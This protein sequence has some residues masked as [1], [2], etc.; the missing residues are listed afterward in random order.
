MERLKAVPSPPLD[1]GNQHLTSFSL[2]HTEY[3][4]QEVR[5]SSE[6]KFFHAKYRRN[7]WKRV[8]NIFVWSRKRLGNLSPVT[9]RYDTI[10]LQLCNQALLSCLAL[11]F[12]KMAGEFAFLNKWKKKVDFGCLC[13][14]SAIKVSL[15]KMPDLAYQSLQSC[16]YR[17]L[18]FLW[19][20]SHSV[21]WRVTDFVET[22]ETQKRQLHS[23]IWKKL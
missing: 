16:S 14:R 19:T 23:D 1:T 13:M 18:K 12:L 10:R 5:S 11:C 22:A 4:E 21:R 9:R 3:R 17:Y 6:I 20:D 8:K 2:Y 15:I 7:C